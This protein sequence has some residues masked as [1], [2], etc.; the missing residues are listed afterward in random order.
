MIVLL[1]RFYCSMY[2]DQQ[3]QIAVRFNGILSTMTTD[4][5]SRL[6]AAFKNFHAKANT[7]NG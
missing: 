4:L 7:S 1:E 6:D 2:K 5:H 3:Y